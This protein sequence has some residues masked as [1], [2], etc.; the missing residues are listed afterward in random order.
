MWDRGLPGA[1]VQLQAVLVGA[2]LALQTDDPALR[3]LSQAASVP[4]SDGHTHVSVLKPA[5]NATPCPSTVLTCSESLVTQLFF[6]RVTGM[7]G[8]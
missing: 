5:T 6:L 2:R 8:L 1:A 4:L 7:K 3:S